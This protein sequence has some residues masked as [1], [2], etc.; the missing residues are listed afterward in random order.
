MK[1]FLLGFALTTFASSAIAFDYVWPNVYNWGN[2]VEVQAHNNTD[3]GVWCSGSIYMTLENNQD[4]NHYFSEYLSSRG[5]IYRSVYP[6]G[7]K[8]I[9]RMNH[10]I[11]CF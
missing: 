10:S 9:S 4:E 6:R 2:R 11:S 7:N 8:R 3:R 1:N 5:F